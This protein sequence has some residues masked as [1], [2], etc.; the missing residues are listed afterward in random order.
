MSGTLTQLRQALAALQ[1]GDLAGAIRQAQAI[2]RAEPRNF[3]AL[4]ILA[5]ANYHARDLQAALR[6]I[7]QALA[8][9]RDMPEAFNTHGLILRGLGRAPAAAGEFARAAQLNPRSREAHYNLGNCLHDMGRLADALAHYDTA[10]KIDPAM[11]MAWNNRGLVLRRMGRLP[12]AVASF[13]EALRRNAGF[14][15]GL[16]NRGD[17]LAM[18]GRPQEA[19]ADHDRAIAL[20]P[21]FAAAHAGR[22]TALMALGRPA[23]ALE[24]SDRA[25]RLEPRA[26]QVQMNRAIALAS[27]GR[28]DA[29]EAALRAALALQPDSAEVHYNL[30]KVL[31]QQQRA[32]EAVASYDRAIALNPGHAEALANRGTALKELGRG[33]AALASLE[34]AIALRPELAEAHSNRGNVLADMLRLEE[35][36]AAH[37]RAIALRPGSAEAHSNRGNTLREMNRLE[38]ALASLDRAI[39]L[40]PDYAE[41]YSNRGNVL[42]DLGRL[43]AAAASFDAALAL[44]PEEPGMRYNKAMVALQAQDFRQGFALYRERWKTAEFDGKALATNAPAWDGS[45]P[46]GPLLLWGEQ[47]IGDEV[48]YASLLSLLDLPALQVTVAADRRLHPLFH[49]SFP[50]IALCDRAG[51]ATGE[52]FAAQA[53]MGDLGHLLKVDA[54]RI[55]ARRYPYLVAGEARRQRLGAANPALARRP[56]CGL[57]WRS[58]NVRLGAARSLGLGDF[59]AILQGSAFTCVNLQY[60]AVDDDIA[61][62]RVQHGLAVEVLRDL[63][64]FNDLDGLA[65]AID[66]CDVVLTI[67]NV[68]A[69]LAGALGKPAIVLVPSGKGRYWYWGGERQSLWYPSLNLVYQPDLGTWAPALEEAARLIRNLDAPPAGR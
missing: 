35:A 18:L 59:A 57:S 45:P 69:H 6:S 4:H 68:T 17:V 55:A 51:A 46:G 61:G 39:A 13:G 12:D 43:A 53:A 23:E 21:D 32:E 26:P 3:D 31:K 24:S 1:G 11:L 15:P 41:A 10:L 22:A 9:R 47:G 14:V 16:C 2:L 58:G 19:L 40:R 38:E 50:G 49:R 30:G 36:L 5:L 63:D 7:E 37:D 8:L 67:D 52:G 62:A 34:A 65:A 48:F 42:R 33:E 25:L 60:G 29:A 27:L 64:V 20:N 44:S 28:L 66:L 54:A 56:V